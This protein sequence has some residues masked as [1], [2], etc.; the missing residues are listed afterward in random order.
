MDLQTRKKAGRGAVRDTV[1]RSQR[2]LHSRSAAA[3]ASKR[4]RRTLRSLWS[5][6]WCPRR[7][8]FALFDYS[9]RR[10]NS[11]DRLYWR[12]LAHERRYLV[13]AYNADSTV[14]LSVGCYPLLSEKPAMS[15][16]S[17]PAAFRIVRQ[18][19][20]QGPRPFHE[21]LRE[22]VAA[23]PSSSAQPAAGVAGAVATAVKGKGKKGAAV[24]ASK[25][26]V[27]P[28]DHPF[29]SAKLVASA[30]ATVQC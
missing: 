17:L 29:I 14:Q 10:D 26:T 8:I 9:Q 15:S 11:S 18:L 13:S 22:G 28:S 1:E 5:G 12:G 6:K 30:R 4:K 25:T 24:Q 16:P 23:V 21:I 27:V 3:G 7:C 19:L 2:D 20:Q